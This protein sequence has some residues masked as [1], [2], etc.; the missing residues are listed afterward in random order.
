MALPDYLKHYAKTPEEILGQRV[1]PPPTP[2]GTTVYK[3]TVGGGK[4][5][6]AKYRSPEALQHAVDLYFDRCAG[7]EETG[8]HPVEPTLSG[9]S[10]ALGFATT[11]GY[12]KQIERGEDYR[13]IVDMSITRLEERRETALLRGGPAT[14]GIIFSL[15]NVHGWREKSEQIN[16]IEAGDSLTRLVQELNQRG[17]VLRP[18]IPV[19]ESEIIEDGEYEEGNQEETFEE[20]HIGSGTYN[21]GFPDAAETAEEGDIEEDSDLC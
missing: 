2:P 16:T 8:I 20:V 13:D 17:A 15:K 6:A 4:G 11:A 14:S 21:K 9:L 10:V 12:K 19:Q 5:L 3:K 7:D 1:L 18:K